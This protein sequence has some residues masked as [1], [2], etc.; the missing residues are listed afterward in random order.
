MV[1][2]AAGGGAAAEAGGRSRASAW[3]SATPA[4]L[5]AIKRDEHRL[6][7]GTTG[8]GIVDHVRLRT[9]VGVERDS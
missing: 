6:D 9:A 5:V 4:T 7:R 1:S 8:L 3:A 2:A